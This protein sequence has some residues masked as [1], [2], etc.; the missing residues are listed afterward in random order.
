MGFH[1]LLGLI[2]AFL[3][4]WMSWGAVS[5]IDDL[6]YI[7][8]SCQGASYTAAMNDCPDGGAQ[9]TSSGGR[10][11]VRV[12]KAMNLDDLDYT[13][14]GRVSDP[15]VKFSVANRKTVHSDVVRNKN[16][17]VTWPGN[18]DRVDL[19]VLNSGTQVNIEVLDAD[20]GFE[21]WYPNNKLGKATVRVPFCSMFANEAWV[22]EQRVESC[23]QPFGC[24]A[25]GETTWDMPD[26]LLCESDGYLLLDPRSGEKSWDGDYTQCEDGNRK[27]LYIK[28]EII[29]FQVEVSLVRTTQLRP[30][31]VFANG[32]QPVL[33]VVGEPTLPPDDDASTDTYDWAEFFGQ[34]FY[35][36]ENY[37]VQTDNTNTGLNLIGGIMVRQD[38]GDK[39]WGIP[40]RV[41]YYL[42]V[43]MAARVYVCVQCPERD[44]VT[45]NTVPT[46]DWMDAFDS[47]TLLNDRL[48]VN[49]DN[50]FGCSK[51]YTTGTMR[52]KDGGVVGGELPFRT[53]TLWRN[54]RKLDSGEYNVLS[55]PNGD[56]DSYGHNY[57]VVIVP[58]TDAPP[59]DT[60]I[61][62]YTV[63]TFVVFL[64]LHGSMF[65][66]FLFLS[67]RFLKKLDWRTGRVAGWLA[68]RVTT[69]DEQTILAQLFLTFDETPNNIEFRL[70]LFDSTLIVKFLLSV[71]CFILFG[72]G[73]S[74]AAKGEPVAL[75]HFIA[76]VG[77]AAIFMVLGLLNWEDMNWRISPSTFVIFAL[78][79]ICFFIFLVNSVFADPAHLEYGESIDFT[80]LSLLFATLN[81]IPLILLVFKQ[82]KTYKND[83][84][85]VYHKMSEAVY[86][87][88]E[89]E[90]KKV[91]RKPQGISA[92]KAL[93]ALM[94]DAYTLN[95]NCSA[96]RF[97]TAL[98]DI[99]SSAGD[100]D[101]SNMAHKFAQRGDSTYNTA[102]FIMFLYFCIAAVNTDYPSLAFLHILVTILF[103]TIHT[104]LSHGDVV[105]SPAF[106]IGLLVAGRV[107]VMGSPASMWL[108]SYSIAYMVYATA[109]VYEVINVMLPMLSKRQAGVAAYSGSALNAEKNPDIAGTP[110]FCFGLIT[111]A[112]VSLLLVCAYGGHEDVLP[113]GDIEFMGSKWRVYAFGLVAVLFV[114]SGGL[115]MATVRAFTLKKLGLLRGWTRTG[116]FLRPEFDVPFCLAVVAEVSILTSGFM[117]YAATGS[118][119]ILILAFFVPPIVGCFAYSYKVWTDNDY[120]LVVWPPIDKDGE[121]EAAPSDME[122]AFNMI[123]GLFGTEADKPVA[124]V[125][126]VAEAEDPASGSPPQSA[127][128]NAVAIKD[129]A[130]DAA[131]SLPPLDHKKG[132]KSDL[133]MPPLPLKSVLRR[134]RA[135][136]AALDPKAQTNKAKA[137]DDFP[138]KK[139]AQ[140]GL[141]GNE[142]G[143]ILAPDDPWLEFDPEEAPEVDAGAAVIRSAEEEKDLARKELLDKVNNAPKERIGFAKHPYV[144]SF[145]AWMKKSRAGRK[146]LEIINKCVKGASGKYAIVSPRE[147]GE[148]DSGSEDEYDQDSDDEKGGKEELGP[149]HENFDRMPFWYAYFFGYLIHSEYLAVNSFLGGMLL[150]LVMGEVISDYCSPEYLG[151]LL[152]IYIWIFITIVIPIYRYFKT[153]V[154]DETFWTFVGFDCVFH[155]FFCIFYFYFGLD[156]DN[157]VAESLWLLDYFFY[158]PVVVYCVYEFAKWCDDGYRI[159]KLDKDGDGDVS[160][161]EALD[162]FKAYPIIGMMLIILNM[163]VYLWVSNTAGAVFT[164]GMLISFVCYGF[165]R[166]WATNDFFLSPNY[167]WLG[168]AMINLVIFITFMA[169][170]FST[171]GNPLLQVCIMFFAIMFRQGMKI[172]ARYMVS[173]PDEAIYFSPNVMPVYSYDPNINDLVDE[174]AIAKEFINMLLTGVLWGSLFSVFMYPVSVGIAICSCFLLAVAV[175]VSATITYVPFRLGQY[176]TLLSTLNIQESSQQAKDKFYERRTPIKLEATHF[177]GEE[178]DDWD[179]KPKSALEKMKDSNAIVNANEL[180]EE[181][182]SM[183]YIRDDANDGVIDVGD[184][185]EV[186]IGFF[187]RMWRKMKA[188]LS[189]AFSALPIKFMNGWKKHSHAL[190][191]LADAMGAGLIAS[192]GAFGFLGAE[193]AVKFGLEKMKNEPRLAFIYKFLSWLDD[194]DE[195]GNDKTTVQLPEGFDTLTVLAR[196][197]DIERAIDHTFKEETRC[198]VHFLLL[199]LVAADAKLQREQVLFQKFLRENRFRLASNGIS[200]P[201][202]IFSSTS[203]ASVDIALVAVWLSTLTEEERERFQ[204][205][206]STFA[207][208]QRERDAAIDHEDSMF[209]LE[210]LELIESR[211]ERDIEMYE[212]LQRDLKSK[213]DSRIRV[214]SERLL[215]ADQIKFETKKKEWRENADIKVDEGFQELYTRFREAIMASDDEA[216]EYARQVLGEVENTQVNCRAGEYG[217]TYQYIDPEFTPSMGLV[218]GCTEAN[219]VRDW[220]CAPGISDVSVIFA[221][222]TDPD[223]V[224]AGIFGDEWLLSAISMLAAAGG[225]GEVNDQVINLFVGHRSQR[226]EDMTYNTDV[227]AY[228]VRLYKYGVWNPMVIDDM[229]PT[230][231]ESGFTNENRGM[232]GAHTKEAAELWVSLIEKA[233]A[234]Y[235]GSYKDLERG[236]VHHALSD[237]TGCESDCIMLAHASRGAGKRALWDRLLH[238]KRDGYVLGAGTASSALADKEILEMGIIFNAAYT[239]Y[240]VQAV[241]GLQLLKLRNPPGDHD[242]WNGDWSDKSTLWTRRLKAKLGWVDEDDNTFWMAFDDFCNVFRHLYVCKWYNP[243][244]WPAKTIPGVWSQNIPYVIDPSIQQDAKAQ[245]SKSLV[246]QGVD[247]TAGEEDA[248]PKF[249]D[250]SGGVPTKHNPGCLLENNPHYA[251]H[252]FRPCELRVTLSQTDSRGSVNG[253]AVPCAIYILR[254]AHPKRPMRVKEITRDTLVAYSGEPVD[255]RT[256]HLYCN[257]RPGLYVI[258]PAVYKAGMT[259]N[260]TLSVLA[261]THTKLHSFWPPR[262]MTTGGDHE[263]DIS[264]LDASKLMKMGARLAAKGLEDAR[265][266]ASDV[267]TGGAGRAQVNP[268]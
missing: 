63:N 13:G 217:R 124:L 10:V 190:M 51:R 184:A 241:D 28:F 27:C 210:A 72:W 175:C 153:Y 73:Y 181:V 133:K 243:R 149:M 253:D 26:R 23:K 218:T 157:G 4:V 154:F 54:T 113:L 166:D 155:F 237:M 189:A 81:C 268:V 192:R 174:S 224:E 180:T 59:D 173:D 80:A 165:I 47:S 25:G 55:E 44:C 159:E 5:D 7:P 199:L 212:K 49:D 222:G 107:L 97:S 172:F 1:T 98:K 186:K 92:N 209:T 156:G 88:Q 142:F 37:A 257:L 85:A 14:P 134:K 65:F 119:F 247:I 248:P 225:E 91:K 263:E 117:I 191:N 211:K 234:K 38:D 178:A 232:A 249:I 185:V 200:P 87:L 33:T 43:N 227:G 233:F 67:H 102:L 58:D 62:G 48:F 179:K 70:H 260:Y 265:A 74:Y 215:P 229:F 267:E 240:D 40:N 250:T 110:V 29:P 143:D 118:A 41:T 52:N 204:M 238:F 126:A 34:P 141:P 21:L 105:W 99:K 163:H 152:W 22:S 193:G 129:P 214:F 69:G 230:L 125:A 120:D 84:N 35:I 60:I 198:A 235:Y 137:E 208:E 90:G 95:P 100:G 203:F 109:L 18:G 164:V 61:I 231:H 114:V 246:V 66:W 160:W 9:K 220:T 3:S 197:Q 216:T 8:L 15:Y 36:G 121:G 96:F 112:F 171:E 128:S 130:K 226:S 103:D 68:S 266:F 262:W 64:I 264:D 242:E 39:G 219:K 194:Y 254:N 245:R 213:M 150:V 170:V 76:W 176:H 228:C 188:A 57:I 168:N 136:G 86:D 93:H 182:R 195:D 6:T 46:P 252:I 147:D 104:S 259:G 127:D 53:N 32:D 205:L 19:G 256:Q 115:V 183:T 17:Y 151:H 244:T 11:F 20:I 77:N 82:D 78:S 24:S 206:K 108:M 140:G 106:K 75:G 169:S 139:K 71:P 83:T 202:E 221:G 145:V 255:E 162:N 12:L 146:I 132:S 116:Y 31:T 158:M 239:I 16:R 144:L 56:A 79:F 177:Y 161:E 131:F 122:V 45:Y 135:G 207:D 94:G 187:G 223:D 2:I 42:S 251:L 50:V 261:N 148:E 111:F 30:D 123:S 201:A 196:L 167:I 258:L 89:A 101:V 236:F 138:L